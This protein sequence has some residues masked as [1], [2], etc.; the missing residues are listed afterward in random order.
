MWQTRFG[1]SIYTSPSGYKVYQNCRY[2]WLTLGSDAL[3]TVIN[4]RHP[5][6]PVL[7]YLP[8][9]TLMA[10]AMPGE[11]CMLGLGGAGVAHLLAGNQFT[12]TITAVESS[13]EVISIARDFF[14]TE[15]IS[16]LQIIHQAAQ[17]YLTQSTTRYPHLIIDLYGAHFFPERCANAAFFSDCAQHLATDGFMAVNLANLR[18]QWPIVQLIKQQFKNTLII[19][20]RHSANLVVL[21]SLQQ[22]KSEFIEQISACKQLKRISLV[23]DWGYVASM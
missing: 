8:A 20:V 19:P 5:A 2:R 10:R 21:A 1:R 16:T 3:Q 12:H 13:S 11:V 14:M 22:H 23:S 9:L 15:Q 6:K 17:D 7:Y 4:K 18:E